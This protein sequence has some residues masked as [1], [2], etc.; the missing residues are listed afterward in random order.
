MFITST[1]MNMDQ[2]SPSH[3]TLY[4]F[5]ITL[6][7]IC[8]VTTLTN[9]KF[10]CKSLS[11]RNIKNNNFEVILNFDHFFIPGPIVII[12][13]HVY[14]KLLTTLMSTVNSHLISCPSPALLHTISMF[15]N[16]SLHF[17]KA[18]EIYH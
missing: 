10:S 18:P 1:A 11:D 15:P 3:L 14:N 5:S 12:H 2:G 17:K 8:C 6:D 16:V 9:L 7:K 13:V 4:I